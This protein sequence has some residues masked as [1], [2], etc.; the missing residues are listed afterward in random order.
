MPLL[1]GSCIAKA[2]AFDAARAALV[3][4]DE[5]RRM[6][7]AYKYYD[8]LHYLPVFS[9][10]MQHAG[11]ALIENADLIIPVPL[12]RRRLLWRKYN[13]AAL[14]AQKI[15]KATDKTYAPLLLKRIRHTQPQVGLTQKARRKNIK[16]AFQ[17]PEKYKTQ[18]A[19]K[20]IVLIDDVVT[21]AETVNECARILKAAGAERVN[22]LSLA[23]VMGEDQ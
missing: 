12:S 18:I 10:W 7:H 1:C 20:N 17:V 16:G 4:N 11:A 8:K 21:T 19:G 6:V 23:R 22:V 15:A 9:R 14:L 2:P 13:Q 3:F 5:A